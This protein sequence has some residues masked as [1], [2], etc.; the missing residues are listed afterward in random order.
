MGK[1]VKFALMIL[2]RAITLLLIFWLICNI[3]MIAAKKIT[4][5]MSAD[6]F[7]LSVAVVAS[8]SM[9]PAL[10][11]DDVIIIKKQE[12]YAEGDIITFEQGSSL[13]T[14]RI[15]GE[16]QNNFI[17]KGDAN[18]VP[19]AKE[20]EMDD[21]VGKTVFVI[22]MAGKLISFF[23]TPLGMMLIVFVGLF[24]LGI[25]VVSNKKY[26]EGIEDEK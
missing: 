6:I 1:G 5:S 21:V 14:H 11:V 7:G 3:Y 22:P 24:L 19:D 10:S 17:T 9:E 13:V 20:V 15:V 2:Q 18:N 16:S 23:R 26:K 8:G 25:P 4:G 12:N